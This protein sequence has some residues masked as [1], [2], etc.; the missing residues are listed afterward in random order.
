MTSN[1]PGPLGDFLQASRARITPEGAGLTLYGDRR[2]VPGLRREELAMLAGVSSSYYTRLEQGQ[3]RNASP[4]V[5]DAIA[6]ALHL[7]DA[8][9]T[10]LRDLADSAGRRSRPKK[11]PAETADPALREL[12]ASLGDVPSLILSR[13]SDVLAWNPLGHLLLASH[14]DPA[15]AHSPATRPN[16]AAL[17]FLDSETRS[18]YADWRAKSRAVVGNLRLVAGKH[19]DDPLLASLIGSLTLASTEFAS[20]WADHRVQPCATAVYELQ[21]PLVGTLT[22]TQQ[23]LRSVDH[24]DQCLVTH[25]APAGSPTT[26]ALT[27]LAQLVGSAPEEIGRQNAVVTAR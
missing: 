2:R 23:T 13:R 24:P 20:L 12:L 17:V 5:L 19:V 8:E 25:T 26:Q 27:L 15:S 3:S 10:H 6:S 1:D 14:L 18:L 11:P 21:H 9:R 22:L 4:Q 7:N 16:M